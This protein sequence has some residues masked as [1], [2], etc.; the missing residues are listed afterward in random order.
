MMPMLYGPL[1]VCPECHA[2]SAFGRCMLG[3]RGL[4]FR[5]QQ[6]S[7]WKLEVVPPVTKKIIYLDQCALSKMVKLKNDPFWGGLHKRLISLASQSLITCPYSPIHVEESLLSVAHREALKAMYREIGGEDRFKR[8]AEIEKAQLTRSLKV[9][10][11]N[12]HDTDPA[13]RDWTDR[14]PH[15]W[16][17]CF[18]VHVDFDVD[19]G[20]V[21]SL[22]QAKDTFCDGMRKQA[23]EWKQLRQSFADDVE[24]NYQSWRSTAIPA[25]RAWVALTGGKGFF[26]APMRVQL[27]HWLVQWLESLDKKVVTP[28][29][30]V[31]RFFQSD[32]WK[33][34]PSVYLW[35][36]VWAKIAELTRNPKGARKPS[37]GDLYDAQVLA[38]YLPYCDAM[39]LDGEFCEIA[40]DE[41]VTGKGR[42]PTKCFAEGR[43]DEAGRDAF[44]EYLDGIQRQMTESHRTAL[45]FIYP[46]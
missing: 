36:R 18:M 1:S 8:P 25:Y 6:C 41:R 37:R 7:Y 5:C 4:I 16:A 42:F 2:V 13:W 32:A 39:F 21:R 35:V 29:E 15:R 3:E 43:R 19:E 10:L 26:F 31:D 23:E 46:R 33:E 20:F 12:H 9:F 24:A 27:I 45:E 40:R 34:V 11:G 28:V 30:V 38:Y 22:R 44:V 17:D 14:N